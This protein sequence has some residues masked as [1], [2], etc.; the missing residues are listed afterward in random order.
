MGGR[1]WPESGLEQVRL[2]NSCPLCPVRVDLLDERGNLRREDLPE[3]RLAWLLVIW[4]PECRKLKAPPPRQPPGRERLGVA[5]QDG[6]EDAWLISIWTAI[7]GRPSPS[8]SRPDM[9]SI[10]ATSSREN[11]QRLPQSGALQDGHLLSLRRSRPLP[12][13]PRNT[14]MNPI[15]K[16]RRHDPRRR[17]LDKLRAHFVLR[18]RV[19]RAHECRLRP[20]R[21]LGSFEF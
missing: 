12:D 14:R 8:A 16:P 4:Y 7:T 9:A 5:P 15:I 1:A 21:F 19:V 10:S 20:A 18:W 11:G 2:S 3:L 6:P 17:S 13:C